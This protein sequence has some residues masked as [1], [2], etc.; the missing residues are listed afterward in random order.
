MIR[1]VSTLLY[2]VVLMIIIMG[3][4]SCNDPRTYDHYESVSLRGWLRNDTLTF[5]IPRQWEGNYQLALGIR[6]TQSYPYRS[7]SMI[8]ERK[9]INYRHRKKHETTYHDT[10]NCEIVTNKGML[11]GQDGVSNTEIRQRISSFRLNRNDSLHITIHHIMS[12][13]AVPG[14]SDIG[15]QL[16]K[17]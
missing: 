6:A 8:M 15:I 9:V 14:I 5:D 16:R 13:D 7:I 12:R 1:K 3:T 17:R 4:A 10:I 11:A 2:I